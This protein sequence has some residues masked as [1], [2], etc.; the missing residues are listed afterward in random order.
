MLCPEETVRVVLAHANALG[1]NQGFM[2]VVEC[3]VHGDVDFRFNGDNRSKA[4]R[5][6]TAGTMVFM[7]QS[8]VTVTFT[9]MMVAKQC[10]NH[11]RCLAMCTRQ[12]YILAVCFQYGYCSSGRRI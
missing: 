6:S 11:V 9:F 2:G 12:Q 4:G 5:K 10:V 8:F 3:T 1:M 7:G